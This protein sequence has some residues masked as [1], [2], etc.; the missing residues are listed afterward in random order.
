[1]LAKNGTA[2]IPL[3][4]D[5]SSGGITLTPSNGVGEH[6][7]EERMGVIWTHR[8]HVTYNSVSVRV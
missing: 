5:A 7:I 1:M 4:E 2:L 8:L 6:G 3:I